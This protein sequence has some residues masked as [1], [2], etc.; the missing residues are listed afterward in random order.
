MRPSR[1]ALVMEYARHGSL[2]DQLPLAASVLASCMS[3]TLDAMDYLQKRGITHRDIKPENILIT[4]KTPLTVKLTDFDL[5]GNREIMSTFCGTPLFVSP[6][7]WNA[8][9]H[10][11]PYSKAIDVWAIGVI[12]LG[13]GF[14][15][16]LPSTPESPLQPSV[17]DAWRRWSRALTS[18]SGPIRPG[19]ELLVQYAREILR[20]RPSAASCKAEMLQFVDLEVPSLADNLRF[21]RSLDGAPLSLAFVHLDEVLPIALNFTKLCEALNVPADATANGSGQADGRRVVT[22]GRNSRVSV[23]YVS[24]DYAIEFLR[25]QNEEAQVEAS[26]IS[27][28]QTRLRTAHLASWSDDVANSG[29][30]SD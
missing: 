1:D 3:Q 20:D 24:L 18:V 8:G 13:Y 29:K 23:E 5:F 30:F 4:S 6:E 21:L 2:A 7:M 16:G 28:M 11:V 17:F 22:G 12:I 27:E 9:I 15:R 19:W 10:R 26:E 25:G 14:F